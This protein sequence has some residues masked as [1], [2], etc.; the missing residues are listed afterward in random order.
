VGVV[1]A[2]VGGIYLLHL[3]RQPMRGGSA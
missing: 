3:M 2:V 1:T